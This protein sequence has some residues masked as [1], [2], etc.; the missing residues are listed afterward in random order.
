MQKYKNN[1]KPPML[2]RAILEL[3]GIFNVNPNGQQRQINGKP[4]SPLEPL[5]R[6][7]PK[8]V[9]YVHP[10]II[11]EDIKTT[12]GNYLKAADAYN[13]RVT[14]ANQEV[15]RYNKVVERQRK[16]EP[17]TEKEMASLVS[18]YNM[19]KPLDIWER[20]KRVVEYN[21]CNGKP[22]AS[23]EKIQTLKYQTQLVFQ[24][25]LWHYSKQLYKRKDRHQ[26]L[27]LHFPSELPAVEIHS[28]WI[29][30]AKI[31][32]ERRLDVCQRTLRRQRKRLQEAGILQDY[33][34]EGSARPVKIRIN[35][36]ILSITD[37]HAPKKTA[38]GNQSLTP[39]GRTVCP[40]NN[41]SNRSFTNNK[42][43][44]ANVDKHSGERSSAKK[45]LTSPN[46]SS[47]GNTRSQG[48]EKNN[49]AAEKNNTRA[50]KN[51]TGGQ[52]NTLSHFLRQKLEEKTDFAAQ[53][54][55]H[56]YDDYTPIRKE[57]LEKEAFSG[58]MS[59]EE[60]KE[61]VL[62]D[63]FKT[64]AKLY[65]TATPYKASWLKAYN[66]WMQEK[67]ITNAGHSLN[68]Q[69][70]VTKIPELRYGLAAVGRYL[71]KHPDYNLLFPGEYFDLT[72][73]TAKEGGFK[74][75]AGEAWRKH[76]DYL[77][78]KTTDTK[79]A[80][81]KRKRRLTDL[82]KAEKHV[83]SYLNNKFDLQE[84][85]AKVEQ[86]G[87]RSVTQDLPEIIRKLN[88]KQSIKYSSYEL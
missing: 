36:A 55:A 82:Q 12:M 80:A 6:E 52:K 45:G 14:T 69:S 67:F 68:K 42:E 87:N 20:N 61:L 15:R 72:R 85:F 7:E 43:I 33:T 32:K 10:I 63:F 57:I 11:P 58:S 51:H 9:K 24:A 88:E 79:V 25:I 31:N 84:L 86:I 8:E 19:I 62:Q 37:N 76:Q 78:R 34:F 75:Y 17:L 71:K 16:K 54:V 48:V 66:T 13:E 3:N 73:T 26:R 27:D 60:F 29:T 40:H 41:V 65:K 18:F 77:K 23:Q 22:I 74:Y 1:S 81:K 44:K 35:P 39:D 30:S 49:A 4:T 70:L 46:F 50:E 53:L 83:K 56:H 2:N 21:R 28:G 59:R 38:A 5:Q 64:A 47:I